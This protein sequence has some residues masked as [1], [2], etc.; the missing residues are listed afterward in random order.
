LAT[1]QQ[2]H[3]LT[4]DAGRLGQGSWTLAVMGPLHRHAGTWRRHGQTVVPRASGLPCLA[5]RPHSPRVWIEN[6]SNQPLPP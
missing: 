3:L 2:R 4:E 5:G 6:P 1:G